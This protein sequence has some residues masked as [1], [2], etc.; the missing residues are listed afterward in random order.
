MYRDNLHIST[1]QFPSTFVLGLDD[2]LLA[3]LLQ[4]IGGGAGVGPWE[5]RGGSKHGFILHS[6]LNGMGG[7]PAV[8]RR[9]VSCGS[10]IQGNFSTYY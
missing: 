2:E 4:C 1:S 3:L 8:H 10:A 7:L 5:K 9:G 6:L